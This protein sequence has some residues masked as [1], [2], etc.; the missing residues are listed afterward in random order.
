MSYASAYAQQPYTENPTTTAYPSQMQLIPYS[1]PVNYSSQQ[2]NYNEPVYEDWT[3][4]PNTRAVPAR[5]PIRTEQV[6]DP[7][8]RDTRLREPHPNPSRQYV[9][10]GYTINDELGTPVA[11]ISA[12][13]K[14][15]GTDVLSPQGEPWLRYDKTKRQIRDLRTNSIIAVVSDTER[16]IYHGNKELWK[17]SKKPPRIYRYEYDESDKVNLYIWIYDAKSG[18]HIAT[19][20]RRSD[21]FYPTRIAVQPNVPYHLLLLTL[22]LI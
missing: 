9:C 8:E 15:K 12:I 22:F 6:T 5:F 13:V 10:D 2:V 20:T 1:P 18:L 3:V 21:G 14:N 7:I 11:Q 16:C 4:A 17:D 19:V